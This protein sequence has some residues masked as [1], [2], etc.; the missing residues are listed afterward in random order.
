MATVK[1]LLAGAGD[2]A[3]SRVAPA[4][5]DAVDSELLAIC[6]PVRERADA[7]AERMGTHAV[8]YD[9]ARALAESQADAVYIATPHHLH[10]EMCLDTLAAEKHLLCEK[11]L[12]INGA[13]CLTLL[14]AVRASDRMTCCSNYRLF[15]N[16]FKTTHNMIA[17][18]ELGYLVGGWAH[19]EERYYNPGNTP[20]R[21]DLGMSPVLGYGFYLI[22]IAQTLFGMPSGVFAQMTSFNCDNKPDY[23]I[24]D[25]ENIVLCYPNGQQFSIIINTTATAPLRHAYQFYCSKGR[26]H[27][28]HCPPHFN[29]PIHKITSAGDEELAD[30][31]SGPEPVVRPNWH[32]AMVE[33][34]VKAVQSN[35][36]PIC[37]IESAVKTAVVTDAIFRSSESGRMEPI[38]WDD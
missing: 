19:D 24:D 36:P 27:W 29:L 11:P 33:D 8:Y 12:G 9:F 4:L 7:L 35:T 20:F 26:I 2:I 30:S 21:K 17:S 3:N 16:Q 31:F 13:E 14:D 34:F 25:L 38:V 15:T 18:G 37:T 10:V 28:P 5:H 22:N 1:W 23:D 6:D 32:L